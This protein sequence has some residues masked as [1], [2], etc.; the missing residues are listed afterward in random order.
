M[1]DDYVPVEQVFSTYRSKW[2]NAPR[3]KKTAWEIRRRIKNS[4]SYPGAFAREVSWFIQ[5]GR[6]GWSDKDW[7]NLDNY[8]T[9]ILIGALSKMRTD[10]HAMFN[11]YTE[12][13][14]DD[15]MSDAYQ[16]RHKDDDKKTDADLDEMI[17]GFK[18]AKAMSNL[19]RMDGEPFD[20]TYRFEAEQAKLNRALDLFKEH[21]QELWD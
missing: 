19:E 18:A 12:L 21:F 2:D 6:R 7:W 9:D 11:F 17:E 1:T 3:W 20:P 5:R 14:N 4:P 13:D 15:F 16:E 10:R 8:L